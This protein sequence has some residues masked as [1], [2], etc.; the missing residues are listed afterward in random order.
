LP[1]GD[2]TTTSTI[3]PDIVAEIAVE[4][5]L[6]G[7]GQSPAETIFRA[8]LRHPDA[9]E[10]LT[11]NLI[12]DLETAVHLDGEDPSRLE[13]VFDW[14]D[15]TIRLL[16]S[17][18][19]LIGA[20]GR[21]QDGRDLFQRTI[22]FA[23]SCAAEGPSLASVGVAAAY[24]AYGDFLEN[25]KGQG[26]GG[27]YS[28]Y[29]QAA[30]H[31][32]PLLVELEM[33]E[34]RKEASPSAA[35]RYWDYLPGKRPTTAPVARY[36]TGA[37]ANTYLVH[38]TDEV[39]PSDPRIV[40]KELRRARELKDHGAAVR[41]RT[42]P[43]QRFQDFIY[44]E[45][46]AV[47]R[48][49][50]A[51]FEA[52]AR[53]WNAAG[54]PRLALNYVKQAVVDL[55]PLAEHESEDFRPYLAA[56]LTF[57]ADLHAELMASDLALTA[58]RDA[59]AGYGEF[60]MSQPSY[61]YGFAQANY[62]EAVLYRESEPQVAEVALE[63]TLAMFEELAREDPTH[64]NNWYAVS[65]ELAIFSWECGRRLK[66]LATLTCT[67]RNTDES[68]RFSSANNI[69]EEP[70]IRL[71]R[72]LDSKPYIDPL[73]GPYVSLETRRRDLEAAVWYR[74]VSRP[75]TAEESFNYVG[76]ENA[77]LLLE[78]AV[79]LAL[80][81]SSD[82]AAA[83]GSPAIYLVERNA[84]ARWEA[85]RALI[86]EAKWLSLQDEL[87]RVEEVLGRALLY[88]TEFRAADEARVNEV[89]EELL[90]ANRVNEI[91]RHF[92]S[93]E[94]QT[95]TAFAPLIYDCRVLEADPESLFITESTPPMD[96][97]EKGR[98]IRGGIEAIRRL[99]GVPTQPDTSESIGKLASECRRFVDDK[100][101]SI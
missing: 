29:F 30:C 32:Y 20:S 89:Q 45:P 22:A 1:S 100:G 36:D 40:S 19:G 49:R 25:A 90:L 48:E 52:Q 13:T 12:H 43:L 28:E 8:F 9:V 33:L 85:L 74:L 27:G 41:F 87:D 50:A 86:R 23:R 31:I 47:L 70:R 68:P 65:H 95:S 56:T 93:S 88:C 92:T 71:A 21:I 17:E 51:F 77:I 6:R 24:Y 78:L 18:A 82:E 76:F 83:C 99:R 73:F 72:Y 69:G 58:I 94:R 34:T 44:G 42:P 61:R 98:I 59:E 81:A 64:I 10:R 14:V 37:T 84:E 96:D 91:R 53:N 11:V 97:L 15:V 62:K 39:P 38:D 67:K 75:V 16:T 26:Q 80:R 5:I 4:R 35:P 66:A 79:A 60:D 7:H 57:G 46:T 101:L 2:H 55:R 54:Y 3:I 63:S